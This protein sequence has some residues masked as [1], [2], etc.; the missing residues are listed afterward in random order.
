MLAQR[1]PGL[2]PPMDDAEAL[3]SAALL[4]LAGAAGPS[5]QRF[6]PAPLPRVATIRP[7]RGAIGSGGSPP[8]PGE[9]SLAHGG[10]LS[11]TNC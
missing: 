10:V 6:G 2:L 3:A 7:A 4:G 5:W 1:L 8:R 11:S 9:I